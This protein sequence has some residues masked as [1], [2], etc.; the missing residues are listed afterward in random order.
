MEDDGTL[1]VLVRGNLDS[2]KELKRLLGQ[3]GIASEIR[4]PGGDGCGG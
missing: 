3:R 4:A 1:V 2:V